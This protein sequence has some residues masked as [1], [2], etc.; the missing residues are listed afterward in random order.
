MC[1]ARR[2]K[3]KTIVFYRDYRKK[4]LLSKIDCENKLTAIITVFFEY[5]GYEL[6][7]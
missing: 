3:S 6:F 7:E 4:L 1:I 5:D 2:F